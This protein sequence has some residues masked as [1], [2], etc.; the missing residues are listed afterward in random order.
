[1]EAEDALIVNWTSATQADTLRLVS[2][3]SYP[4][5]INFPGALEVHGYGDWVGSIDAASVSGRIDGMAHKTINVTGSISDLEIGGDALESIIAGDF[6]TNVTMGEACG[7]ISATNSS[8]SHLMIRGSAHGAI[9]AMDFIDLEILNNLTSTA[10]LSSINGSVSATVAGSILGDIHAASGIYAYAGSK[11]LDCSSIPSA[12]I[13]GM[14]HSTSGNVD[15][16]SPNDIT[17]DISDGDG[18]ITVNAGHNLHIT[19]DIHDGNGTMKITAGRNIKVDGNICHNGTGSVLFTATQN[20]DISGMLDD[21]KGNISIYATRGYINGVITSDHGTIS[22]VLAAKTISGTLTATHGNIISVTASGSIMAPISAAMGIG[23]IN[24]S[25]GVYAGVDVIG[26]ITTTTGDVCV[27]AGRDILGIVSGGTSGRMTLFAGHN[28]SGNIAGDTIAS[29]FA[30]YDLMGTVT[31]A[32]G[33]GSITAGHAIL[34]NI[35]AGAGLAGTA[36]V[37]GCI[38]SII[39]GGRAASGVWDDT[40]PASFGTITITAAPPARTPTGVLEPRQLTIMEI[41][42]FAA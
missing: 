8:I 1:L 35:T 5:D 20:V 28:S 14:F 33:I 10:P 4:Y 27:H 15:L 9:T 30:G 21:A 2:H 3:Q 37:N 41:L 24:D 18:D 29:I 36:T 23:S 26:N 40:A 17:G 19:G 31:A 11:A 39:A 25:Q 7:A 13:S 16:Y 32:H 34:G 12:M 38:G 42:S 6:I 22:N